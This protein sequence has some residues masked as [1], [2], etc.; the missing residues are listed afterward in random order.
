ME[1]IQP[2]Y[3]SVVGLSE[4]DPAVVSPSSVTFSSSFIARENV[5]PAL[6]VKRDVRTITGFVYWKFPVGSTN[7]SVG[8]VNSECLGPFR[9]WVVIYS[10]FVAVNLPAV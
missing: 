10:F 3:I 4:Y 9:F 6:W 7:H 8:L 5:S 1:N 2:L